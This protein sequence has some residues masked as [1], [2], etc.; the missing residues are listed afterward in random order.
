[1]IWVILGLL[2]IITGLLGIIAVMVWA[3]GDKL[4]QK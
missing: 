4:S 2:F 1:M 3:I